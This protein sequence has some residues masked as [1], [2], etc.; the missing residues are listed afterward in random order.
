LDA[1]LAELL[2]ELVAG[3]PVDAS[4]HVRDDRVDV[5]RRA[6]ARPSSV[7]VAMTNRTPSASSD[8]RI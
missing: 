8:R 4:A 7:E 5:W 3:G 1:G 6:C 2:E